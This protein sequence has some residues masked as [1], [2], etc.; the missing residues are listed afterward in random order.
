[1]GYHSKVALSC[2]SAILSLADWGADY[3]TG[4]AVGKASADRVRAFVGETPRVTVPAAQG[5]PA[6]RGQRTARRARPFCPF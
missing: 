1:M 6:W 2:R 3:A 4:V 5:C